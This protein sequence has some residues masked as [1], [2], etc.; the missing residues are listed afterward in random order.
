MGR[1]FHVGSIRGIAVNVHPSF[2][3]VLLWVVYQWGISAGLGLGGVLFGTLALGAVFVCVL[4]HELAHALVALRYGLTV[5]DIT[6]LPI[7]G[8]A[9]VEHVTLM[10]R[11][12]ATIALA[13]PAMNLLIAVALTPA[14][15]LVAAA[16]HLDHPVAILLYADETSPAG[17]ILYL[18]IT[19]LLLA[20]FNLLPAFPMDGGRVLRAALASVHDRVTATRAAVLV[21]QLFAVLLT[22]FGIWI[23]DYLLPLVSVFIVVAAQ[24]ESRHVQLESS[25]RALPVGQFALWESGGIRPDVP[26][27]HAIGS[28]LK[29]MVVT[30]GG[31]VVGM[32]WRHDILR[33]LSD[34]RREIYVQDV[35]DRRF[36]AVEA[37]DSVYDVHLWLRDANRHAVAVVD[38]RV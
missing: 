7:G 6:L 28:G 23:G 2:A 37:T 16:R 13:G 26:L 34:S 38:D 22:I 31:R 21:G 25:L 17:F 15:L 3:L 9:R 30:Q 33:H 10:P 20:L 27:N 8:V 35:M 29:D 4:L 11:A 19:N 5:R 18:W 32:L 36:V 1:S 12:E 14:V 24:T